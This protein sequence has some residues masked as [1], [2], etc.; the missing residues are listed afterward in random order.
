[1][2]RS[3]AYISLNGK[4]VQAHPA[5]PS[6]GEDCSFSGKLRLRYWSEKTLFFL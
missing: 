6:E 2:R 4:H 3:S 5:E 1:M